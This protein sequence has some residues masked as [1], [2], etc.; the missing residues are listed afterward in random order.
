M[1]QLSQMGCVRWQEVVSVWSDR[2]RLATVKEK[3]EAATRVLL[4]LLSL[5]LSH[6]MFDLGASPIIRYAIDRCARPSI[7][8]PDKVKGTRGAKTTN[9]QAKQRG[10]RSLWRHQERQ[11]RSSC[12]LDGAR[13][14]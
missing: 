1:P 8:E 3:R 4:L 5:L 2:K 11:W 7:R 6:L 10:R 9:L 14:N 12:C 13:V